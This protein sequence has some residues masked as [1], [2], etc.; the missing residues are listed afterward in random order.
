MRPSYNSKDSN[1]G[2]TY[3]KKEMLETERYTK[4]EMMNNGNIPKVSVHETIVPSP[5]LLT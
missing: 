1:N 3:T 4:K 2:N 5:N